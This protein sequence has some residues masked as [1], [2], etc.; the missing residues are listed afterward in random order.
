MQGSSSFFA[1][2]IDWGCSLLWAPFAKFAFM[3]RSLAAALAQSLGEFLTL[4]RMSLLGDALGI[5]FKTPPQS[6]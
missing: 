5:M 2:F 1:A 6:F 3:R 4:R